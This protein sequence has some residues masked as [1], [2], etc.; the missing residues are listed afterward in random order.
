[1]GGGLRVSISSD[2]PTGSGLGSSSAVTTATAAAASSAFGENLSREE[3]SQLAFEAEKKVQGAASRTGVNVAT[4]GGF[5]KIRKE[6]TEK[7][8]ELPE[9]DI[10]IGYTGDYG[11][12]GKLVEKVKNLR[13]SR[14]EIVNPILKAI[15]KSTEKGIKSFTENN[16]RKVGTLMNANQALLEGLRVSSSK[17]RSLIRSAREAGA[18]GAKLTGAGGGGCMIALNQNKSNDISE[19]IKKAGGKP[20]EAKIGVEGLKY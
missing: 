3:I 13:D 12:T 18:L 16:L 1:M 9:L 7:L 2:I 20:I 15:G 11:D 14:P 19:A 10:I 5:L 6:E 8:D 4:R 17:L